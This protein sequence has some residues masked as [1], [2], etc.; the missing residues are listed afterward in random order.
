MADCW[1]CLELPDWHILALEE[2]RKDLPNNFWP[3][4][5]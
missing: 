2:K 5:F 3:R 4:L 1:L